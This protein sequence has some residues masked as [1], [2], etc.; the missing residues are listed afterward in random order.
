MLAYAFMDGLLRRH[1]FLGD[2]E[3][4]YDGGLRLGLL[5]LADSIL[6]LLEL[7][8]L[9]LAGTAG[10]DGRDIGLNGSDRRRGSSDPVCLFLVSRCPLPER[11]AYRFLRRIIGCR[12]TLRRLAV[13]DPR[14]E[15]VLIG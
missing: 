10:D 7:R 8:C 15:A 9:R 5:S 12:A 4:A 13:A 2:F 14:R 3:F 1:A 6:C 11:G